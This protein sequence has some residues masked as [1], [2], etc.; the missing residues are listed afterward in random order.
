M[1]IKVINQSS[2]KAC[3]NALGEITG[4]HQ[5]KKKPEKNCYWESISYLSYSYPFFIDVDIVWRITYIWLVFGY[6]IRCRIWQNNTD[7]HLIKNWRNT[8]YI[9]I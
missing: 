5:Y 2:S 7:V 3:Y 9:Y 1:H 4:A 8:I 6:V